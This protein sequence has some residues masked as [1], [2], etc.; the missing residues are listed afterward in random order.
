MDGK[1]VRPGFRP[2]DWRVSQPRGGNRGPRTRPT[3]RTESVRGGALNV[4]SLAS[5]VQSAP[6]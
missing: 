1:V 5:P 4:L 6:P 2:P 3:M